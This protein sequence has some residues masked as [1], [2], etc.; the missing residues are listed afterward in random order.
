MSATLIKD[1]EDSTLRIENLL[2]DEE[3]TN[4]N[5]DSL[6]EV[7][8]DLAF[9]IDPVGEITEYSRCPEINVSLNGNIVESLVDTGSEVTAISEKFYNENLE[10]FE[11]CPTLPLCGKFI[12]AATG[13]KSASL[14]LQVMIPTQI[15]NLKMYLIYIVVP[16]LIKDCIIGI[17]SQEKLKMII[18]TEAKEIK[19]TVNDI[20]DS[21]SYNKINA[22]ESKQYSSLNIIECLDGENDQKSS[23]SKT[24]F[25]IQDNVTISSMSP[26]K[27]SNK[28]P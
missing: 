22:I 13:S 10:Y 28:K 2:N 6:V 23:H 12:K 24:D 7:K 14:K 16:K 25:Q 1:P 9:D 20:S 18:N 19:I 15:N 8:E 4:F 17:D 27:R 5:I 26:S 21:I 11:S 3:K